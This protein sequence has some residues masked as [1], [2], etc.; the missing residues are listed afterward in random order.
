MSMIGSGFGA[1]M[2]VGVIAVYVFVAVV[3]W[4]FMRAHEL[5]AESIKSIAENIKKE[6]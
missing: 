1:L 3:V 2:V 5:I 4:R 6:P